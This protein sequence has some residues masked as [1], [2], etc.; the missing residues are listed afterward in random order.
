MSDVVCRVNKWALVLRAAFFEMALAGL[1]SMMSDTSAPAGGLT[2]AAIAVPC[3]LGSL[4]AHLH[5]TIEHFT[6]LIQ[7]RPCPLQGEG[8]GAGPWSSVLRDGVCSDK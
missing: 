4:D 8:E 1:S 7:R 2:V 6:N 5:L 3:L